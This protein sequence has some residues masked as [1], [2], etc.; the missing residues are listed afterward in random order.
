MAQTSSRSDATEACHDP[1]A[2][3]TIRSS[4]HFGISSHT[5]VATVTVPTT[6]AAFRRMRAVHGHRF[7]GHRGQCARRWRRWRRRRCLWL[8]TNRYWL[9]KRPCSW[10]Y[11]KA[12]RDT[13]QLNIYFNLFF[14]NYLC[15]ICKYANENELFIRNNILKANRAS[16][17]WKRT[18]AIF[19]K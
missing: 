2:P 1:P 16:C 12:Y 18:A 19:Y 15:V 7:Y 11:M 10:S 8:I 3:S 4:G 13:H 17:E 14:N 6:C 9:A 5:T